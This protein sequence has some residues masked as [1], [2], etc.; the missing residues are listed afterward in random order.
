MDLHIVKRWRL[1]RPVWCVIDASGKVR[2]QCATEI[3]ALTVVQV[4]R[5]TDYH[6]AI[7]RDR[8]NPDQWSNRC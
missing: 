4:L 2:T 6:D 1:L 7:A 3:D 8:R 5:C